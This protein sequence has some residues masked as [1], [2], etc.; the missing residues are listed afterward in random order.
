MARETAAQRNARF[1][2]VR[3]AQLAT[4]VALYPARLMSVLAR[5]T[6]QSFDL[7]VV[8]GEFQVTAY[9]DARQ[10]WTLSYAHTTDSW[11]ELEELDW[12][13]DAVEREQAEVNRLYE[14]K[15]E[16]QRKVKELLTDEERELLGLDN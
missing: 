3:E 8:H 6:S 2:A 16:A 10:V 11:S 1:E 5:A 13:L 4:E 9:N 15:K 14:V 7:V 12:K